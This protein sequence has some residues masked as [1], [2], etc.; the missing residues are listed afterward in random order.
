MPTTPTTS[1]PSVLSFIDPQTLMRIKSLQLRARIVVQGFLS[2][3]HRSPHHGFSVEF[4]E[5]REYSPGDDP[6]HLDWKLYARSDRYYIK[7][8]EEETNLRCHILMDMS[9]SMGFGTLAYTKIDYARTIAATLAYF[10]AGQRDAVGLVTFDQKIAEIAPARYRPG[11]LHRLMICLERAV[12]GKSTNLA[13]PLEQ[14]AATVRKRGMVVLISDLLAPAEA[15]RQHLGFLRSQGHEVMIMRVLD[16]AEIS[17]AFTKAALFSDMETGRELYIDPEL[18][19][20]Q[21]TA[22]FQRHQSEIEKL[23]RELGIDFYQMPTSTPLELSLSDFIRSRA[24][25]RRQVLRAGNRGA[26][27]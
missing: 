22:D 14:V 17:F 2:G 4:S 18:A 1:S 21:Y 25:A 15:L 10:L 23:C 8:F 24:H 27:G 7:R 11:H 16:P 13:A 5:Y 20:Q 12:A 19:R 6:R 26:A 3:L 9:R